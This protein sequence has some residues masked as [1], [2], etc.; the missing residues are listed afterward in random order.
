LN[1]DLPI[2]D[3]EFQF[4]MQRE[5]VE[6]ASSRVSHAPKTAPRSI[7]ENASKVYAIHGGFD[8]EYGANYRNY[9]YIVDGKIVYIYSQVSHENPY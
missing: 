7:G 4:L 2:T 5:G 6:Y 1:V 3:E 9:A 8:E